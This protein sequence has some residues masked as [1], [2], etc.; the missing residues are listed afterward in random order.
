[1]WQWRLQGPLSPK[2]RSHQSIIPVV[3]LSPTGVTKPSYVQDKE[4]QK[5]LFGRLWCKVTWQKDVYALMGGFITANF[6]NNLPRSLSK[7]NYWVSGYVREG[8]STILIN[9]SDQR[10][11]SDVPWHGSILGH[12]IKNPAWNF[13]WT[14]PDSGSSLSIFFLM[15][16][17]I[18]FISVTTQPGASGWAC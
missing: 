1:M 14:L 5:P 18:C 16:L 17:G 11:I 4:E 6:A 15:K 10:G 13:F 8:D 9:T 7:L 2:L 3:L 12:L